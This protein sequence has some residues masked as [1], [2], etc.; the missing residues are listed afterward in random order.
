MLAL[1]LVSTLAHLVHCLHFQ[2]MV[3]WNPQSVQIVLVVGNPPHPALG[4]ALAGP[5]QAPL[6]PPTSHQWWSQQ[7]QDLVYDDEP[8]DLDVLP[9][10][11]STYRPLAV[12]L[13]T[14]G[15]L[16]HLEVPSWQYFE[17]QYLR[18]LHPTSHL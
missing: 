18:F 13:T 11:K 6:G 15:W 2:A 17:H 5:H 1:R 12:T 4:H 16:K 3:H 9:R 8:E 10:P 7:Q 14:L